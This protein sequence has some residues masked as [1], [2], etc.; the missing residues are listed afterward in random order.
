MKFF[1]IHLE[2]HGLT[3]GEYSF[4]TKLLAFSAS[5]AADARHKAIQFT[6]EQWTVGPYREFSS[7]EP[8]LRIDEIREIG[9]FAYLKLRK[10]KHGHI[11]VR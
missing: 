9:F 2:G 11:F 8:V 10:S 4:F 6:R 5:D 3:G 7:T 1:S